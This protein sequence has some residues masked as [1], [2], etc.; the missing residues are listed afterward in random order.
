M[1]R[2]NIVQQLNE[3]QEENTNYS[4]YKSIYGITLIALVITI[5]L[6]LI[7][8][9][10]TIN[11]ALGQNGIIN[12]T[13]EVEEKYDEQRAKEKLELVLLD[14]Q[15]NKK[16]N[17]AYNQ[18]DY[19]TTQIE[20]KGMIVNGDTIVVDGWQFQ[21]DRS[22]PTI[23]S[24]ERKRL[25]TNEG[26]IGKVSNISKSG[27][28]EVE[29]DNP[30]QEKTIPYSVHV[31]NHNGDLLLDGIN[32]VE[33]ATLTDKIYEFGDK[34][35]DSGTATQ[36][37]SNT[38]VL[39]VNGDLIINEGVTLTSCKSDDGYGGPKGMIISCS[40]TITNNGTISMTAR[41]AKAE[42]EDIYLW[43]NKDGKYEYVPSKGGNGGKSVSKKSSSAAKT[44]GNSGSNGTNRQTG[45][46]G[47]GSI[48][49]NRSYTVTSGAGASGTS[50][51]GGSGR[52]CCK[53]T[54]RISNSS[55]WRNKWYLWR[56]LCMEFGSRSYWRRS[57]KSRRSR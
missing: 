8:A 26:L 52:R 42:G 20:E 22:V 34:E 19:L 51:S 17:A 38:V 32:E 57:R 46:G 3:T 54:T 12:R 39:K 18:D 45:G 41:G 36:N 14:M 10:I 21:I 11:L 16:V 48:Y 30:E 28:Y 7:L 40:G 53:W 23:I 13:K 44:N 9:G 35:I 6:L 56:T 4:K 1:R 43:K 5:I 15:A 24:S 37:A 33:G 29:V 55:K 50:Y 47:A 31:I 27:Y 2:V 25:L 49:V